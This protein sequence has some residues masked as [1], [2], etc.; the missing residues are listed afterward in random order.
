[1]ADTDTLAEVAGWLPAARWF[2][3]KDVK[4]EASQLELVE[5]VPL[6]VD[7]AEVNLRLLLVKLAGQSKRGCYVVPVQQLPGSAGRPASCDAATS[8]AFARWLL[9]LI[10]WEGEQA[11]RHGRLVGRRTV[12]G[13]GLHLG[14]RQL[15]V[16]PLGGDASNTSLLVTAADGSDHPAS[17]LIKVLRRYR[18]GIQPEVEIGA[19][20]ARGGFPGSPPLLGWLEY[21][22]AEGAGESGVIATVHAGIAGTENLWDYLCNRSQQSDCQP[23]DLAAIAADLGQLTAAMHH[24]LAGQDHHAAFQP[25]QPTAA[26]AEALTRAMADHADA[27]LATLADS[28]PEALRPRVKAVLAQQ[29]AILGRLSQV[30]KL[31]LAASFIRV[32]G[33]YHLGQVLIEPETQKLWVI[34]FE[35]EPSRSLAERRARTSVCKDVTGIC[36]SFDYLARHI[37]RRPGSQS[38]AAEPLATAFL[39]AYQT[40]ASGECFW[41]AD[42]TEAAR[43]LDAFTLDKALYELAYELHHRPDWLEVPLAAVER[44]LAG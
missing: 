9:Q 42:P 8:S 28:C 41:P 25:L 38:V 3:D 20:L 16:A 39:E 32:H 43:L 10:S 33:D 24:A 2:A 6:A 30:S 27:V 13:A 4:V 40:A 34:D 18:T 21:Q 22:P 12:V 36:R 5:E 23:E 1:M 29:P 35:G 14:D 44:L 19:F 31:P 11:G 26:D 7:P 37:D 17:V 15:T